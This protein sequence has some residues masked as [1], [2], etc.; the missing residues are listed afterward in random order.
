MAITIPQDAPQWARQMADDI[1]RE[2]RAS[3]R[4]FPVVLASFAAA[5]LP[6]PARWVGGWIW[7]PDATGG[8]VPAYSDGSAWRRPN[9]TV[10]D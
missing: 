7:V 8:P 1:G 5:D 10:I 3:G 4:G 9:S 6:D 2:M